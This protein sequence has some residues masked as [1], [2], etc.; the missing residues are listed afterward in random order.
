[1]IEL[2]QIN[3]AYRKNKNTVAIFNQLDFRVSQ[4]E[5]LA[6]TGTSG[7]GKSTLL[8]LI[9]LLDQP[10]AGSYRINSQETIDLNDS[11]L[12]ML[13]NSTFGFVFQSFYLLP[14]QRA[15]QNVALPLEYL[16]ESL[17]QGEKK[18]RALEALAQVGLTERSDHFPSELSGGQEQR[19]AIARA[20]VN[21]PKVI[22]ADEPTGNLDSQTRDEIIGLLEG[23]HHAGSTLIIVTH[24]DALAQ[25]ATRRIHLSDGCV[26]SDMTN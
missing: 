12:S 5:Y 18:R 25:R 2:N 19:V 16:A 9:G 21:H 1:V 7:S 20:I 26:V 4:G 3:F 23:I 15:W 14:E 17:S 13:R 8:N 10:N 6:I 11:Q 24:D 22:L